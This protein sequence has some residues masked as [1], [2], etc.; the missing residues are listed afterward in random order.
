[1]K[2][3]TMKKIIVLGAVLSAL[4]V[5]ACKVQVGDTSNGNKSAPAPTTTEPAK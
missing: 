5:G 2:G 4:A 3:N 1:M